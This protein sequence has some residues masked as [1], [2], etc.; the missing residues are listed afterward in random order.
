MV[1]KTNGSS[2]QINIYGIVSLPNKCCILFHDS[3]LNGLKHDTYVAAMQKL[4]NTSTIFAQPKYVSGFI[5][6][7][8]NDSIGNYYVQV[9]QKNETSENVAPIPV[10]VYG[11]FLYVKNIKV[12]KKIITCFFLEKGCDTICP[13][14]KFVSLMK[15]NFVTDYYTKCMV[16]DKKKY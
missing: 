4:L 5:F 7:L 3:N 15:D 2:Q 14:N 6:E 10:N 8:R 11:K 16:L 12:E 1:N 9:L 13:F